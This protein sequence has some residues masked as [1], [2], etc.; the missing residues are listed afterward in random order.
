MM[1]TTTIGAAR[2]T[3]VT[4]TSASVSRTLASSEALTL[5]APIG[6]PAYEAASAR[7]IV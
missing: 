2:R 6:S 4:K 5:P 7:R 1:S 3:A